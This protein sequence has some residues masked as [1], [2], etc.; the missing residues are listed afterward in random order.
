METPLNPVALSQ[1]DMQTVLAELHQAAEQLWETCA[2]RCPG[3][4][5][6][7]L[8]EVGS[9]NT[10][11]MAQGRCGEV[12][13]TAMV[14]A[15]QTAGRGRRGRSWQAQAGATLT[16]SLGLPVRLDAVPGGG[17][18]LSLAVGLALAE[19][20]DAGMKARHLHQSASGQAPQPQPPT[21]H[22]KWPN[23]LWLDGRKLGGVLIEA[24]PA[25][26]LAEG[27]RWVVV[28]VGLNVRPGASVP[29]ATCLPEPA[30]SLGEVWRWLLPALIDAVH[31]F[32]RDG[33]TPLQ[34]NYAQR[35]V[36]RGRPVQLWASAHPL[37]QGDAMAA[38]AGKPD[39]TGIALGVDANGALLVHTDSGP[40]QWHA[41]EVSIRL[42]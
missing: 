16:F 38:S 9:T 13:P 39:Q 10:A 17:G 21:T 20:L 11:L 41:G 4:V 7:V 2:P 5:L 1:M 29:G 12:W 32:E 34:A 18:A 15:Q 30:P 35:D 3:L 26:G 33:F 25:P 14:A 31:A 27:Q 24:T 22:L 8:P 40:Q 23:D 36:L 6:D 19:A 37:S 28:G 42:A